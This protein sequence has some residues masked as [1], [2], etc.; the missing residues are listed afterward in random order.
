MSRWVEE[1]EA[2]AFQA[3][4]NNLKAELA[5]ATIDDETILTAVNELARLR[6]VTS[7]LD[8]MIQS[9][10]PELVPMTTW[11][12]F[13]SQ[14][15][16]SLQQIAQYNSNRNIG[17]IQKAN[18]HADNLLSY[19]RPYMIAAGDVGKALQ[20]AIKSYAKTIDE[21]GE[22]FRNKSNSLVV[23]ISEYTKQSK[24]LYD[25]IENTKNEVDQYHVALFGKDESDGGIQSKVDELVDDFEKKHDDITTYYNETLVGDVGTPST[26]KEILQAKES[27]LDDKGKIKELL[28]E[29]SAEVNELSKFYTRIF[30]KSNDNGEQE[31]GLSGE[32]DVRIK[33]LGDFEIKQKDRYEA[34]NE[35]IERLLPGATSAGLASAYLDMKKSFNDP[36]KYASRVFYVAIGSL[37]VASVLLAIDS[38]GLYFINFVKIGDWDAVLKGVVNKIPF[39]APILWLAFYASK[40]RSEYQRLQQEYAH[41]EALAKSYDNYKKQIEQLD[42]KDMEMQ[43]AFIMKAIDAIA[44]N[45]SITLDGKHG[46]KMPTQDVVEKV[47]EEMTKVKNL[48]KPNS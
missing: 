46:D 47:I 15:T 26:K 31:G 4:W 48:F 44:Y 5:N 21:Y 3:T 27:I 8:E 22:S 36:I 11:D 43:K 23:E 12:N 33:A 13:N 28:E 1:F 45:A 18:T 7:Y 34:L 25:H 29:V 35:Q 30:G 38:V 42:D 14:A 39:Y 32:L 24:E 9:I 2:H 40:R 41:K 10:D 19:I 16:P 6:K 17:H 20:E 37:V